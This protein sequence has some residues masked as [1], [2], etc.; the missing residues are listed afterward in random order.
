MTL[1]PAPDLDIRNEEQLAAE[2]IARVSGGLTVDRIDSQIDELRRLRALVAGGTLAPPICPELTNANPSSTHTVLIEAQAWLE[3]FIARR[4]NQLPVRDA[5]EFHRLFKIELREVAS[6]VTT[7]RFTVAPPNGTDITIPAGSQVGTADGAY[8]FSTL[9]DLVIPFG[10][11][12]GDVAAARTVAGVT[13]LAPNVLTDLISPVAFIS[14]V[15]NPSA[16]ASG[17]DAETVDEALERARSYQRRAERLVSTRDIEDAILEDA[18]FGNGIVRAFPFVSAGDF[19]A[20]ESRVGH[21][22]VVVMTTAGD[23]ID[24]DHKRAINAVLEL[25]VGNQFVYIL[26]PLF[27]SFNVQAGVRLTGGSIQ[28]AVLKAIERNLRAAYAASNKNFGRRILRSEIIAIIE[29]TDGVDRIDAQ[30]SGPIIAS[31][32]V[33]L[34]PAPWEMPK[35]VNVTIGLS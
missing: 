1:I 31:P 2:A 4:I 3:A 33:D 15:T 21:T 20:G 35:L 11:A 14:A 22:T 13:V 7:L 18:L 6:A 8:A 27:V 16:V 17:N 28:S 10:Q 34:T 25:L 24:A 29:D 26:D 12:T 23:A 5:I 19:V 32:A 9:V 30:P